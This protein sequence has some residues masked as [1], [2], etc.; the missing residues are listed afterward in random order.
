VAALARHADLLLHDCGG[1]HRL[2]ED[3]AANHS[4]AREAGEIA[5][6]AGAAGL[7]LVHL[8]V[9]EEPLLAECLE[10]AKAAFTGPVELGRDGARYAIAGRAGAR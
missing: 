2:R 4:S 3:F 6:V 9:A 1:P 10:E 5:A 7:V 8:G